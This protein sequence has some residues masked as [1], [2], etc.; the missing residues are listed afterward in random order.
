M[1]AKVMYFIHVGEFAQA[2]LEFSKS[3]AQLSSNAWLEL[4]DVQRV[5]KMYYSI[6]LL[7]GS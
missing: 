7:E 6:D 3:I 1:A 4:I 2:R 5:A